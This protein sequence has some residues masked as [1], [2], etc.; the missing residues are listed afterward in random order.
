[1]LG[2]RLITVVAVAVAV[3]APARANVMYDL[4]FAGGG[5][6]TLVLNFNSIAAAQ[7]IGYTSITPYFI[8]L[9]ANN[10]AGQNFLIKP[11]NLADGYIS[12][13]AIGQLYTLTVEQMQPT[14]VPANTP[15]LDVYTNT[16]QIHET[17]W[18]ATWVSNGLSIGS[19]FMEPNGLPVG[20]S[21]VQASIPEPSTWAMIISGV[22]GLSFLAYRK[23]RRAR[24][25][26]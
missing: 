1:M 7:N 8:S 25:A 26:T 12:T 21:S 4:T 17:P 2:H 14:G 24:R 18:N 13:G 20:S 10:V 22:C 23:W 19:P 16:W 6:G 9:S 3:S 5:T 11:S 15:F